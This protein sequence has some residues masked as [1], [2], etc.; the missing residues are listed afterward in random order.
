LHLQVPDRGVSSPKLTTLGIS[1]GGQLVKHRQLAR[2]VWER[3][4]HPPANSMA[5]FQFTRLVPSQG[6]TF[7][8]GSWVCIADG[9]G[10][11]RRFLV[12]MKPKN[13]A[14]DPRSDLDKFVDDLNN[15]SIHASAARIEVSLFPA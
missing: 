2:Q 11:F 12:D 8:F 9:V 10:S 13:P 5:S 14:A 4:E 7:V 3:I 6:T 15:L 1:L